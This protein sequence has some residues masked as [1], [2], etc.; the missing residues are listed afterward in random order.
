MIGLAVVGVVSGILF[1]ILDALINA[2]PLAQKLYAV[3]KPIAKTSINPVAGITIDIV[4][5]FLMAGAFLILYQSLPGEAGI[6]KGMLTFA[7][8]HKPERVTID[9]HQVIE[10]TIALRAYEME[11][12]NIKIETQ[13]DSNLP[14][15]TG[16]MGQL[17][18]VL[19]NIIINAEKEMKSAH[20]K[21]NLLV[22]T[23]TINNTIRLSF[24]DD[25][26]GIARKNL[27]KVFDPFFTTREVGDGAGLGL[28]ICH[29]IV[30]E[31]IAGQSPIQ[32]GDLEQDRERLQILRPREELTGVVH[33]QDVGPFLVDGDLDL[34]TGT[35]FDVFFGEFDDVFERCRI[36]AGRR[37]DGQMFDRTVLVQLGGV[38]P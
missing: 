30:A 8:Q 27:D 28:S 26:P 38:D 19:L 37:T 22:K 11:T 34:Q 16:D 15:M 33:D 5:G 31:Q 1:C 7:R 10:N 2:N 13:F 17:Q 23:E 9:I 14:E 4:F 12:N 6:V 32:T 21:G 3:Y 25:G 36:H 29:G 24:Q 18:Q 35:V 20:G